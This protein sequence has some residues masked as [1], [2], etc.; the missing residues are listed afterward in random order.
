[1]LVYII[2]MIDIAYSQPE[3]MVESLSV[4]DVV[5]DIVVDGCRRMV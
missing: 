5:T 4:P 2:V 1:M 3:C